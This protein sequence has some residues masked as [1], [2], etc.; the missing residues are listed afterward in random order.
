MAFIVVQGSVNTAIYDKPLIVTP[1]VFVDVWSE[2]V[3]VP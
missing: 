2:K 3:L 1:L